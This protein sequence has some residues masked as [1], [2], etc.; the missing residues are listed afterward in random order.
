VAACDAPAW[1]LAAD[2]KTKITGSV[3]GWTVGGTTISSNN[4]NVVLNNT[5]WIG[6]KKDSYASPTAGAFLGID[7]TDSNIAKFNVGDANNFLKWTGSALEV[8]GNLTATTGT[9]GGFT[10]GDDFFRSGADNTKLLLKHDTTNPFMSIGQSTNGYAQPGIFLGLDS[11]TTK[12]S[13]NPIVTRTFN[14]TSSST[15]LTGGDTTNLTIGMLITGTGILGGTYVE[16]ITDSTTLV[17]TGTAN[18]TGTA[19]LSFTNGLFSFDGT[20]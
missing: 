2:L 9:I 8:K 13:I 20:A 5:G 18:T 14:T 12:F 7:T 15:T 6:L 11:N 10:T 4:N 17:M 3:G 16:S 1:V 19:A